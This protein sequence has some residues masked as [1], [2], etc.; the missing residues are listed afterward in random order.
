MQSFSALRTDTVSFVPVWCAL[1]L[2]S[3]DRA[4]LLHRGSRNANI[5]V[6]REPREHGPLFPPPCPS[7]E[8]VQKEEM[9]SSC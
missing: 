7:L 1:G 3:A 9:A 2:S 6:F 4:I 8:Y 5:R